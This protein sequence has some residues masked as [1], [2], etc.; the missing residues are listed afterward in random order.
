MFFDVFLAR[1]AAILLPYDPFACS[2]KVKHIPV[3]Q[4]VVTTQGFFRTIA[5]TF[6]LENTFSWLV[7]NA[8]S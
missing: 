8:S 5:L 1:E 4:L 7:V 2:V 6:S 3:I